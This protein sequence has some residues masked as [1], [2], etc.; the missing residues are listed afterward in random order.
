[1]PDDTHPDVT[2]MQ[3]ELLRRAG[4]GRRAA[5]ARSL[6]RTVIDL[7]RR[8]L[9]ARLPGATPREL[10]LRWVETHYGPDL[11]TRLRAFLASRRG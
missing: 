4:C 9:A 8:E 1:M 10:E 2:A 6:S 3:H 11:G 5:L 7:S